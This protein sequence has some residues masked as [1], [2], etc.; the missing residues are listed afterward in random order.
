MLNGI[1]L[2]LYIIPLLMCW[3]WDMVQISRNYYSSHGLQSEDV[4]CGILVFIIGL[5]PI[6]NAALIV[7]AIK[8]KYV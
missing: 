7:D 2:G 5:I 8:N 1:L 4:I 3:V 6:M